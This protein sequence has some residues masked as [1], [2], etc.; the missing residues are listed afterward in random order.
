MVSGPGGY[1]WWK[2]TGWTSR[3]SVPFNVTVQVTS[4]PKSVSEQ[5]SLLL[6]LQQSLHPNHYIANIVKKWAHP[7]TWPFLL[8]Q[9]KPKT[10]FTRTSLKITI[11]TLFTAW[12]DKNTLKITHLLFLEF[13]R[14]FF[15][16]LVPSSHFLWSTFIVKQQKVPILIYQFVWR[17]LVMGEDERRASIER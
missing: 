6:H 11:T 12:K 14:V 15:A 3:W 10:L 13:F 8:Q 16:F 5:E 17:N 2:T 1:D 4:W 7:R 9:R